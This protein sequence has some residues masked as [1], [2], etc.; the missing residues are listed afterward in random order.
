MSEI[1]IARDVMEENDVIAKEVNDLLK[2]KKIFCV[3]IIS[4]PG[5]GKTTLL[6]KTLQYLQGK[7]KCAVIEGDISTVIDRDRLLPYCRNV[8]QINTDTFGGDCHLSAFMIRDA[9]KKF[10]L[11]ELE[12][13]IIENVGNLICPAD[14][15]IGEDKK[16]LLYSLTEGEDKPLKY[17]VSFNVADVIV[18]TKMDLL[19]HLDIDMGKIRDN[20][21]KVNGHAKVYFVS[22]K[23]GE[24]L[25]DWINY[26][27]PFE[28]KE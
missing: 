3:N 18:V 25:E 15:Y 16:I 1:E 28:I 26:F 4:S 14:F 5:A 21:K 10:N 19:P 8:Y 6:E 9:L 7:M 23:T 12:L 27:M 22:A 13:I 17:P 24:G 2:V 20:I 11:D